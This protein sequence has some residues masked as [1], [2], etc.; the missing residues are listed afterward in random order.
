MLVGGNCSETKFEYAFLGEI[1]TNT[2]DVSWKNLNPMRQRRFGHIA[3]KINNIMYVA[4]GRN[5]T[6]NFLSSCEKYV[7]KDGNWENRLHVLPCT[8]YSPMYFNKPL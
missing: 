4:G 7:I 8:L 6:D 5:T 3:F 2:M 1:A